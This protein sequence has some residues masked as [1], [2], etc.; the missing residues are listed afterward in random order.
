MHEFEHKIE[1]R[2]L[3]ENVVEANKRTRKM[4]NTATSDIGLHLPHNIGVLQLL[5]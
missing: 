1:S 5:Q 4:S 2:I 3:V